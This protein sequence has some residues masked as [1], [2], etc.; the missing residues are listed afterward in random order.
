MLYAPAPKC[1]LDSVSEQADE[2]VHAGHWMR[3]QSNPFQSAFR[4]QAIRRRVRLQTSEEAGFAGKQGGRGLDC[5][6][7]GD[8]GM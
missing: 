3:Q 6:D 2:S 5:M 8:A 4:Q 7:G 1:I